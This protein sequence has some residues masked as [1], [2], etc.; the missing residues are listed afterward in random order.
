MRPTIVLTSS[1]PGAL[2]VPPVIPLVVLT[3]LRRPPRLRAPRFFQGVVD[4]GIFYL[5]RYTGQILSL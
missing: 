1:V 4:W 2:V 3:P 5:C